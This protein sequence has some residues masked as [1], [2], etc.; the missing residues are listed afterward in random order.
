MPLFPGNK[1]GPYEIL[2]P[3]GAGGMGE[4]YRARDPRL[5][6]EVAIKV[7]QERF[8]DRFE[9]EARAVAAL[10]HPNI[11]T[12]YDVGPDYL[13]MELI[14]GESPKGPLPLE[15]VLGIARQIS[16][17]L[18][19]AHEKGIVHR[20]LKPA[21]IK[22][23]P[24]GMVKVL[25]FGLAKTP[26]AP[27]GDPESSPT[28]TVSPTR[29]GMIM[30]T[31]AYMSPEQARGKAVDK[32]SD[33][34]AFGVVLCELLTGRRPF[35]GEDLTEILA[36]VMK[37]SPDLEGLPVR[38]RRL[39]A[40]CL[41]KDPKKRL[42]DIG[43][44]WRLLEDGEAAAAEQSRT[45]M[46][47]AGVAL[48]AI[49]V[50][51]FA[52]ARPA[53]PMEAYRLSIS[54]PPG[55]KFEFANNF[56]GSAISPDGRKL[57]FIAGGELWIR[58]L[59]A[60]GATKVPG[61]QGAYYP[62]WSPDQ[63]SIAFFLH[64]KLMRTDLPSGPVT[65]VA[66]LPT[67]GRWGTWNAEGTILY[68]ASLLPIFRVSSN[69]GTATALTKLDESRGETAHY[70]PSFFPDGDHFLYMIRSRDA[71]NNGIYVGS[72]KDPKL[73]KRVAAALSNAAYVA[74]LGEH[75]GYLLFYREGLLV[76]QR[77]DAKTFETGSEP[78]V[79]STSVGY[80]LNSQLACFSVSQ[81]G[82]VVL[83]GMGTPKTQITWLDRAGNATEVPVPPDYFRLPR[84]SPDGSRLAVGKGL[85]TGANEPW[86]LD[87]KRG[88]ITRVDEDGTYPAW[89]ADGRS[90]TYAS[91]SAKALVRKDLEATQPAEVIAHLDM[92]LGNPF[93]RSPDGQFAVVNALGGLTALGLRDHSRR[94]IRPSVNNVR[95]SPDGKWLAYWDSVQIFVEDFPGGRTR[96]QVSTHGGRSPIWRGDQKE[97]F[98]Q[99]EEGQMMAV[100]V[101]PSA[102]G[103]QFGIPHVLFKF[104]TS[105]AP[106]TSCDVNADGQ[107][108]L[109][110]LRVDT[111]ARGNQ[112]TV[113]LNWRSALRR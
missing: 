65:E 101:K 2:A 66:Q 53:S 41:E 29:A 20:D 56:G 75:P 72:L 51:I 27:A 90:L 50:A 54:P 103:L 28:L 9:R 67:A 91:I 11:C 55:L 17:A 24:D 16:D 87:F 83:G 77:F 33:I 110:T 63:R 15:E 52:L 98:Y 89:S 1:L 96:T 81:T 62:F 49:A 102:A 45:W 30:G 70:F 57:A 69:G 111:E 58:A 105:R 86:V 43:D 113:L 80:M 39:I 23:K 14:E 82:T 18:D 7:S 26:E 88:A 34:W 100:D 95:F 107:R 13:V 36:S 38:V 78:E 109:C 12:L 42:R 106:N 3:I 76:A 92:D 97:L 79:L 108:F 46:W 21:N 71:A 37:D 10:N 68:S 93:D 99:T 94:V 73:K 74:P 44:A 112:L 59:D 84:L 47:T 31:A 85:P 61:T 104:D 4:V 5:N 40:C 19:A 22:I 32:R 25:D 35:H 8:S 64:Q 6:R 60:D 48:V